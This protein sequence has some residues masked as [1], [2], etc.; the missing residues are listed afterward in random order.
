MSVWLVSL[1]LVPLISFFFSTF[2][3]WEKVQFCVVRPFFDIVVLN[4]DVEASM[5]VVCAQYASC[6]IGTVECSS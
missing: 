6:G 4:H 2:L 5:E 3:G 1:V